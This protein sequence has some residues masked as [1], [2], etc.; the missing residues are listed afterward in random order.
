M[1]AF[2]SSAEKRIKELYDWHQLGIKP[3]EW[4]F[5]TYSNDPEMIGFYY[6]EDLENIKQ[7]DAYER[8]IKK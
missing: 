3:W 6:K 5:D 7:L 2:F 1:P 8:S 4:D